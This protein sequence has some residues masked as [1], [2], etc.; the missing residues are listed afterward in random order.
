ML[1]AGAL[2]FSVAASPA[3]TLLTVWVVGIVALATRCP[4]LA[5]GAAMLLFGFEGSVKIL[6]GLDGT[7]LPGGSRAFGAA[8]LDV[9]LFTAIVFILSRDR[10][11]AP[12]AVWASATRV[13]RVAIL[14]LGSWLVLSLVG[15]VQG[16]DLSRG[17]Q[18]FRLFQSYTLVVLAAITVF[19]DPRLRG[20]AVYAVLVVGLIVSSY[21]ALRVLIGPADVER[22][23]ATSVETVTI[24]GARYAP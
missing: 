12:R 10:L 6:L 16:G 24:T 23:F 3:A 4:A 17:L 21:A 2:T 8:A 13:E 11:R 19:A 22:T 18:G 7:S 9:A 15:I 20:P 5:F 14:A 1:A